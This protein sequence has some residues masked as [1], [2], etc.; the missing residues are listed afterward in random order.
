MN[1]FRTFL[2]R[3]ASLAA[4][5]LLAGLAS[6]GPPIR[7]AAFLEAKAQQPQAFIEN[8]GQWAPE[9]RFLMTAPSLNYWVTNDGTR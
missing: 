1:T 6:A 4:T 5:T 7:S 3:A 9:A 2:P 8:R